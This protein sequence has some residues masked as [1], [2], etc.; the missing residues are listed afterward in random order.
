MFFK[1]CKMPAKHNFE[2]VRPHLF[3]SAH[4]ETIYPALFRKVKNV[5][6]GV[7][8]RIATSD[9]DFL[10]L[11]WRKQGSGKLVIIQHGL[12]G[13]ADRPYMLGMAKCFYEYGFDALNWNFRGCSGEMNRTARFY[14]SGATED[15]KQVVDHAEP[16]YKE[17]F[18]VGFSLGG[19]LTLKYLGEAIRNEKIRKAVAISTPLDLDNGVDKLHGANGLIYEKRFIRHLSAK[20]RAKAKIM[21]E[22]I[23]TDDL[24]KVKTL[25]DFD[26]LYTAPLHGFENAKDYYRKCSSRYFL[27]GIKIPTLILNSMNDPILSKESL[28]HELT[29]NL[30]QVTLETTMHGGHV[31]Y[32]QNGKHKYYWSEQRAVDFCTDT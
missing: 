21:P 10:D 27:K 23:Q 3:F 4:L 15:L 29:A 16:G 31:G 11:E 26:D 6:P 1:L 24:P 7:R 22:A 25:R 12:E 19:N 9:G 14:H 8:E 18:L 17:I 20:V 30:P 2:Y 28:D 13:S 32:A 5:P